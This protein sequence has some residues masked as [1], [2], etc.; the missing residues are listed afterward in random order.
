MRGELGAV[1]QADRDQVVERPGGVDQGDLEVIV[2]QRDD[3]RAGVEPQDLGEVGAVDAPRFARGGG[4]LLEVGDH[5]PGPIDLDPGDQ[6]PAQLRD[7]L[8]QVVPPL[9]AVEGAGVHSP[10]LVHL[11]VGVGGHEQGVVLRGL[12]VPLPGIQDLPRD[13]GLE[14]GIGQGD[15]LVTG[16]HRRRRSSRSGAVMMPLLKSGP[17]PSC[18]I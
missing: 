14:D 13:Q 9:D 18:R 16:R 15:V 1:G 11:E 17:P 2:L 8:D 10:I 5:V 3:H 12:D 4:L 6:V 7:P